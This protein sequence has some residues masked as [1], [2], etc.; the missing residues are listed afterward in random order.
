MKQDYTQLDAAILAA[1]K[2]GFNSTEDILHSSSAGNMCRDMS[3]KSA[4]G[5]VSYRFLE[6]RLQALRKRREIEFCRVKRVWG[7]S[8]A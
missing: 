7:L 8:Q 1:I 4:S 5:K 6:A 3:E 2:A